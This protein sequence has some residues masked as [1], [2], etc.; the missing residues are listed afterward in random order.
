VPVQL[1]VKDDRAEADAC[2][3]DR[4]LR[5]VDVA[6]ALLDPEVEAVAREWNV[7]ELHAVKGQCDLLVRG[8]SAVRPWS[9][10]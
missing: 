5:G 8:E 9:E 10:H 1:V 2:T 4:E 7:N 6:S 3:F